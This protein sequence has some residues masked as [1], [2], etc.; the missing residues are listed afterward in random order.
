MTG[1]E[2]QDELLVMKRHRGEQRPGTRAHQ[3]RGAEN[4]ILRTSSHVVM[5]R[6]HACTEHSGLNTFSPDF[7]GIDAREIEEIESTTTV[8]PDHAQCTLAS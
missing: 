2:C 5:C 4:C 6:E 3:T 8:V 1:V 7:L